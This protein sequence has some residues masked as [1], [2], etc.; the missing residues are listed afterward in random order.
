MILRWSKY[1]LF[2]PWVSK[3]LYSW[4]RCYWEGCAAPSA[5]VCWPMEHLER[6]VSK[7]AADTWLMLT[8]RP[9]CLLCWRRRNWRT[10]SATTPVARNTTTADITADR[11]TAIPEWPPCDLTG[12]SSAVCAAVSHHHPQRR[13][14]SQPFTQTSR[15]SSVLRIYKIH[16]FLR[17]LK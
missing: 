8:A 2:R 7:P 15:L 10:M 11:M 1:P 17:I 14:K 5:S 16:N 9:S 4:R 6:T 12:D 13:Y 3:L